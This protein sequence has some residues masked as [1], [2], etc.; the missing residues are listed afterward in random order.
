[1]VERAVGAQLAH[2]YAVISGLSG[3]PPFMSSRRKTKIVVLF[4]LLND[5]SLLVLLA[6]E[7]RVTVLRVCSVADCGAAPAL[8]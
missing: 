2:V 8:P 1:M 6:F 5:V 4:L 7:C 3:G